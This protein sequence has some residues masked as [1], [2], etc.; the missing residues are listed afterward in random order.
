MRTVMRYYKTI[1]IVAALIALIGCTHAPPTLS[2][3]GAAAFQ[4]T[5]VVKALDVLQDFAI[6]AEAQ[7]PKL[8]STANTRKVIDVVAVS[9]RAIGAVPTGWKPTVLA[10]LDQLQRDILPAEWQRLLPYI[11]LVRSVI[12]VLP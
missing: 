3:T 10:A 5:R 2:P 1:T 9:V 4:A 12:E 7:N 6:A 11:S 8:L